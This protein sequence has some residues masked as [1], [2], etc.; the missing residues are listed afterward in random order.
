M[1]A[2]G[3]WVSRF[4]GRPFLGWCSH[5]HQ[6]TTTTAGLE[7]SVCEKCGHVW[8][9][10]LEATVKV[11]PEPVERKAEELPTE[12]AVCGNKATYII[13]TGVACSGHA[14]AEASRQDELGFNLWVPIRIDQNAKAEG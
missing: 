3:R 8:L 11:Y 12:C 5:R 2:G 10:Y 4:K 14:W 13:P 9:R 1:D 7:R 6:L